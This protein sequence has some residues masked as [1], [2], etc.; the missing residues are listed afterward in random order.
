M[1]MTGR[2]PPVSVPRLVS[3]WR[4]RMTGRPP[5]VPGPRSVSVWRMRMTG[6]PPPV[7][8]PP[9]VSVW[10]MRMTGRLPAVSGPPA[11][12]VSQRRTMGRPRAVSVPPAVSVWGLRRTGRPRAAMARTAA[13]ATHRPSATARPTRTPT[14]AGRSQALLSTARRTPRPRFPPARARGF[15]APSAATATSASASPAT[16]SAVEPKLLKEL[17]RQQQLRPRVVSEQARHGSAQETVA[18]VLVAPRGVVVGLDGRWR[19]HRSL[20]RGDGL[21]QRVDTLEAVGAQHDRLQTR[22]EALELVGGLG[23][24][25]GVLISGPS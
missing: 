8:G 21:V 22:G 16:S 19:R 24:G 12:S 25:V 7:S 2:T 9:A 20:E 18:L 14:A 6:R 3:V 23:L 5:A 15:R 10:R 1:R 13:L 4:M 11:A 17:A